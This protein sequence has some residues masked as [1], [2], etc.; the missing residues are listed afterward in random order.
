VEQAVHELKPPTT[1]LTAGLTHRSLEAPAGPFAFPQFPVGWFHACPAATLRKG[2]FSATIGGK[3]VAVFRTASGNLGALDARCCH[4]GADLGN[5]KVRGECLACPFHGWEFSADGACERIPAAPNDPVPAFARQ[6]A[7]PVTERNGHVFV[8][9]RRVA[10]FPL[11]FFDVPDPEN[12]VAAKPFDLICEAPWHVMCA[13]GF[14]LQ[15]FSIAHER[16]L[17]AP[18]TITQVSPDARRMEGS[19]RITGTSL[20]DRIIAAANGS[21]ERL[22]VTSWAGATVLA[23]AHF[24]RTSTYAHVS[25]NPI[26]PERT[27]LRSIVF[28]RKSSLGLSVTRL[29]AAIKR[30]FIVPFL[31][32]ELPALAGVRVNRATLIDADKPLRDYLEWL[33]ATSNRLAKESP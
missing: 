24:A 3:R 18:A 28:I 21:A 33:S 32:E 14:D 9:N 8:C 11:P 2:P 20:R 10:P 19:F 17:T 4:M 23:E 1:P 13:N 12:L 15:H 31:R 25:F 22:R 30:M 6:T 27:L 26:G 5:G 29:Q 7:Y 16:E